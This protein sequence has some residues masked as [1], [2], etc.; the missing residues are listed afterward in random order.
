MFKKTIICTVLAALTGCAVS[1][2]DI[3]SMRDSKE[4][5]ADALMSKS[6]TQRK[7]EPPMARIDGNFV[8]DLPIDLPYAAKLPPI[9]FE[10][11]SIRAKGAGY[12]TVGQAAR[13]LSLATGVPIR[14]TPDVDLPPPSIKVTAAVTASPG[15]AQPLP[16]LNSASQMRNLGAVNIVR[17]DYRGTFIGYVKYIAE[18]S[19]VD[20]EWRDGSIVFS[21]IVTKT[22]HLANVNPGDVQVSDNMT[23]GGSTQTGQNAG[24][25][26]G[27]QTG[28][29]STGSSVGMEG[30]YSVWSALKPA[31]D[32]ALTTAGKVSVNEASG[33]VTVTDTKD[34]VERVRKIID[35]E[36]TLMGRQVSIDVRTIRVSLSKQTQGSF[37][38]NAVYTILN[39]AGAPLSIL[40]ASAPT[41]VASST[42]GGMMTFAVTDTTSR[43]LGSR[44]GLQAMNQFGT[45]VSDNT[46]SVT[47]TNRVPAMTGAYNTQGFLAQTTPASGGAVS[48]GQ[49][50]PGL[51]PGSVTTGSFLRVLP[52]IRDN[53]T[54]ML[55]MSVDLSNLLGFGSAKTGVG[56]TEQQIQWANTDGTKT[57][58]N[59][60]VNQSES[61]VMVGLGQESLNSDSNNGIGGA[62]ANAN[63]NRYMFIVVVTPRIMKGL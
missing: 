11:V 62:S 59:L 63:K 37:D 12:G 3:S 20:W 1:P 60:V 38:L 32:G 30:K 18:S 51:T 17:M 33:T 47:T 61:M 19:G 35:R 14:V 36:D 40:S 49:G 54:I 6:A 52:T 4:A 10:E 22:F 46:S 9:F 28:T 24:S 58:S 8:G 45:I 44:A 15:A 16:D 53:N 39:A 57:T 26:G 41:S 42:A 13:N 55:N 48:G 50:I 29:F 23:K 31:L 56:Q 7:Q 34:A 25:Q 21:R 27:S 43:W 5:A 2:S